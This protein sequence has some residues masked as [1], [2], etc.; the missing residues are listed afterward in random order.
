MGLEQGSVGMQREGPRGF[1]FSE[2]GLGPFAQLHTVKVIAERVQACLRG[3]LAEHQIR[4]RVGVLR[5]VVAVTHS[6]AL[7]ALD[8][9]DPDR[10]VGE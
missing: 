8:G 1:G 9:C 7:G 2:S 6:L 3:V 4:C 5:D 10:I